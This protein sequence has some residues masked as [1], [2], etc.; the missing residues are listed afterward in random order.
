MTDTTWAAKV[1]DGVGRI[2][3]YS[4]EVNEADNGAEPEDWKTFQTWDV[5][6]PYPILGK[7]YVAVDDALAAIARM[8][9]GDGWF[10]VFKNIATEAERVAA[11]E[12][13]RAEAAEAEAAALT[14][15]LA[16]AEREAESRSAMFATAC[17]ERNAAEAKIATMIEADAV[18]A[19]LDAAQPI[20]AEACRGYEEQI[21]ALTAER[22]ELKREGNP[23]DHALVDKYRR[24]GSGIF[25]FPDDVAAIIRKLDAAEAEAAALRAKVARLEGAGDF[26]R[27]IGNDDGNDDKD[28]ALVSYG[29]LRRLRAALT[30]GGKDE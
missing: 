28:T 11:Y 4:Y 14:A 18:Q 21:A 23:A 3:A 22:D 24:A 17:E 8:G 2:W 16:E 12:K 20:M 27:L 25:K 29:M 5:A 26:A 19:M 1:L 15:Q 30:D 6:D 7:E 10:D 9:A 13:T